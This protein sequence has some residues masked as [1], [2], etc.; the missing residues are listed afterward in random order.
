MTR[1]GTGPAPWL[2]GADETPPGLAAAF[3]RAA[4]GTRLRVVTVPAGSRGTCLVLPGRT[5]FAEKY[6]GV[7]AALA[8]RG[9]GAV[10]PDWRGQG[11]SERP[12]GSTGLGH[13]GDFA[14][15]G[16]DLAAALAAAAAAGLPAPA[17]LLAHSMGGCIG[18]Q[19]LGAGLSV[20]AAVFSAP[21][22]GLALSPAAALG[23]RLLAAA[24]TA[25]GLGL[26]HA[27]G[28]GPDPYVLAQG[29][30]G[31]VLTSDPGAH[32]ALRAMVAAHPALAL[33]GPSLGWVRAAF[34]A[35]RALPA[36]PAGL[37]VLA[38]LGSEE[39]VV[40]PAAIRAR[41]AAAPAGR[42][43]LLPGAR[44]EVLIETPAIRAR[45]WAEI[46]TTLAAAGL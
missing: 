33:G 38:L 24:G 25:L 37:P 29:F 13:V 27:P 31:N 23:A 43:V 22:W 9:F 30:Q 21:M 15:Y 18:L 3:V 6:A 39:A 5:E 7:L 17:L 45:A 20:R 1:P 28:G 46:D 19:A 10:L 34:R 2:A 40:S 42:L 11:L 35:M 36:M 4:D 26:R 14:E 12:G 8:A 44:H 41:M 32:A 16:A